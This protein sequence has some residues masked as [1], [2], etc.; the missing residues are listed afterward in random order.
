[1]QFKKYFNIS[2]HLV[3]RIP[4]YTFV[5]PQLTWLNPALAFFPVMMKY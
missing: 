1:M 2:S 3:Y 4:F 5:L